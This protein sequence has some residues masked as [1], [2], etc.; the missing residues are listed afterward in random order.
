MLQPDDGEAAAPEAGEVRI[1]QR[2]IGVN[3]IDV[4]LRKGWI[5]AMLPLPGVPG[6]EAAGTWSTSAPA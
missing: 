1:R 4:Y 3:Y 5:P 6:M 2:A